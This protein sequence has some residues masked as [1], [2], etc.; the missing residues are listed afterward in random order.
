MKEQKQLTGVRTWYGDDFLS[1]Q[2]EIIEAQESFFMPY[3]NF[4]IKGC[5]VSGLDIA[6]GI[7]YLG[8]KIV[9]F[10]GETVA[11]FPVYLEL[12]ESISKTR[13]Y[14]SGGVKEIEREFK[15]VVNEGVPVGDYIAIDSMGGRTFRDAF[16]NANNR[17]VSDAEKSIWNSKAEENH[18]HNGLYL[19]ITG[20]ATDADK[21][22]G[23]DSSIQSA[24][25][26]VAIRDSSQNI[27][28]HDFI[29]TSDIRLKKDIEILNIGIEGLI[30]KKFKFKDEDKIRFGF[31][32]QDVLATHPDLVHKNKEGYF[33]I[34]EVGVIPLLVNEI[35]KMKEIINNLKNGIK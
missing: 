28:A 16:Q 9:R 11:A 18:N 25:N 4:I 5:E 22:D 24:V 17:M 29:T 13:L 3:G 32:A 26:S 8:G 31:V 2:N 30:P 15:A 14:E 23:Y 6:E 21:I 27:T 1:I 34:S 10:Y 19:G 33:S 7:C 35:N 12:N 20:K